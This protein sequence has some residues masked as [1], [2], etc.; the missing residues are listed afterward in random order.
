M[1]SKYCYKFFSLLFFGY[2]VIKATAS[3]YI[4]KKPF[5]LVLDK[6]TQSCTFL[7]NN[8]NKEVNIQYLPLRATRDLFSSFRKPVKR[9]NLKYIACF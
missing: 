1:A 8:Y 5:A 7:K 4:E 3:F 9:E 2:K 6:L